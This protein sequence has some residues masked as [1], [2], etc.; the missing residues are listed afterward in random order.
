MDCPI[1]L[2]SAI[3]Q[4]TAILRGRL[5]ADGP[6]THAGVRFHQGRLDGLSVVL[7]ETGIGKVNAALVASVLAER[8]G[9]GAY[10]FAGVAGGLDPSL[11][12]GD[13]AIA[14]QV[15]QHDYGAIVGGRIKPYRPGAL[16]FGA[17]RAP[18][19]FVVPEPLLKEAR[20]ALADLAL[21]EIPAAA[22]G[23]A[24]RIPRLRFGTV[25]TG[26]Q[27]L[28]C[29]ETR[30][31]LFAEHGALAIEMEGAAVAQVA[32]AYGKPWLVVRAISDLAGR[33]S[34][35]DFGAFV[36]AAAVGA[37]EVVTRLLPILG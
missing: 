32:E 11:G 2:I 24:P 9:V 27:F 4:E 18:L 33:D 30:A 28:G 37:A 29:E 1:G 13:V 23:A 34:A 31:R 14:E 7:V 16:P 20:A 3:S 19:A 26:D 21:P 12:I 25:L 6:E 36:E 10:L 17:R 15:I 22:T 5:Q 35:R 8:F